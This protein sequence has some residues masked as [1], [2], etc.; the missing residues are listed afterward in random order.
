MG[1]LWP[2]IW[3][4]VDVLIERSNKRGIIILFKTPCQ[5]RNRR[6]LNL[7]WTGVVTLCEI[8]ASLWVTWLPEWMCDDMMAHNIAD[9]FVPWYVCFLYIYRSYEFDGVLFIVFDDI[10]IT[11]NSTLVPMMIF[12]QPS[13]NLNPKIASIVCASFVFDWTF[14]FPFWSPLWKGWRLKEF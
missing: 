1:R 12:P 14:I 7:S 6:I 3:I 9:K 2:L 4:G 10:W 11:R 5:L 8:I 13:L